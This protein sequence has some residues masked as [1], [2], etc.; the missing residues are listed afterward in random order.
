MIPQGQ[1]IH[2]HVG[3]TTTG[4][5]DQIVFLAANRSGLRRAGYGLACFDPMGAAANSQGDLLPAPGGTEADLAG[6]AARIAARIAPDRRAGATGLILSMPDLAGPLPELLLGRF[7]PNARL[8]ARALAMALGQPVDRLVL[9]IQPYDHLYRSTWLM[10]AADRQMDPLADYAPALAEARGGWT[11]LALALCEELSVRE[12]VVI[13]AAEQQVPTG[14]ELL[15]A[16][17]P[18]LSLRQA[19]HPL[20][21]PRLTTGA[22]ALLARCAAQGVKLAPG[23]RERLIALHAR[24]PEPPAASAFTTGQAARMAIQY[25]R[26]RQTLQVAAPAHARQTVA[27][28]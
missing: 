1:T 19:V 9:T 3:G 25:E 21:R 13:E 2:L 23:Q 22:V 5:E 4:A 16:L 26:D 6:A 27:A 10:L 20:S 8:R 17:V 18:G 11:D 28:E 14:T 7:H 12:L 15:A 24:Q